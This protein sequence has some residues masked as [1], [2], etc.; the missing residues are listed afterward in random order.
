MLR[1]L[2]FPTC[3]GLHQ[4]YPTEVFCFLLF[5]R[6]LCVNYYPEQVRRSAHNLGGAGLFFPVPITVAKNRNAPDKTKTLAIFFASAKLT[7]CIVISKYLLW[8]P[9]NPLNSPF[10]R[11]LCF[12]CW[13]CHASE[14]HCKRQPNV[15]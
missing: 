11:G 10:L 13:H 2:S 12:F 3:S 5:L 7:G 9:N 15:I 8:R 4:K 6:T 14:S 1:I